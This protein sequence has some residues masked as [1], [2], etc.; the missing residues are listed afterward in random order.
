MPKLHNRP[1][2]YCRVNEYAVIYHHGKPHYLGL[3]GSPESKVAYS[4]FV[5]EIQANPSFYLTK[6]ETSIAVSELAAAFLDHVKG[7]IDSA[8]YSLYRIIILEFLD[9]LYG[10]D[11]PVDD[12]KPSCLKLVRA[13]MIKSRRFCRRIVNRYTHRLVSIFAWGVENDLVQE[14]TW[15]AL[16]AV[17]SLPEGY[18]GTFDNDERQPVSDDVIRR[19]LPFL[20]PTLR[21]M[22]QVQYLTG[23]RPSEIF[24]MR[25]GEIDRSRGNGLWY[26]V[27]KHHKTKKHIGKKEIPLGNRYGIPEQCE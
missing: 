25:V 27:P 7:N 12:F 10:D 11:I 17:K 15:R 16:K 26:Y 20:P 14:T 1:P 4:R 8:G 22:V 2:K 9:K 23:C 3:Y 13:E 24:N 19:T 5:A 18:P 6:G 21:A